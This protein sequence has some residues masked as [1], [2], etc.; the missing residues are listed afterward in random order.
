MMGMINESRFFYRRINLD[1]VQ[2]LIQKYAKEVF[3]EAESF[4]QF[5]YEVVLKAVEW[6]MWVEYGMGYEE[7]PEQEE[8]EYVTYVSNKF[9]D[10]IEGL[11]NLYSK[12]INEG[13]ESRKDKLLNSINKVG[14]FQTALSVGGLNKLV[15]I[16]GEDNITKQ[17]KID[18]IKKIVSTDPWEYIRFDDIEE[19]PIYL[20][21]IDDGE[22]VV[23]IEV[24][25]DKAP[26]LSYD[27]GYNYRDEFGEYE[28]LPENIITKIF[29]I[30]V[31]YYNKYVK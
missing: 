31:K 11:Y 7:L 23:Q 29:D 16:V 9:E 19:D 10:M 20:D 22:T 25:Y 13:S 28:L 21:T 4:D 27:G 6:I 15:D 5:K 17:N 24:I 14:I 18:F 12:T 3:Y 2:G 30:I 26:L 1:K 8:I